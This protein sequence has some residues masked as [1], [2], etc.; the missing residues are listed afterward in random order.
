VTPPRADEHYTQTLLTHLHFVPKLL[1][2]CLTTS[3]AWS[4]STPPVAPVRPVVDDY[5]GTRVTDPYRWME[6]RHSA[7]FL[8]WAKKEN[9]YTRTVLAS[10]PNRDKLLKRIEELDSGG[11]LVYSVQAASGIVVYLKRGPA[12]N[13]FKL[14]LR[15]GLNGTETLLLDPNAGA[16][17]GKHSS[18]DYL[19]LSPNGAYVVVGVSEGGSEESVMCFIETSTGRT[20]PDRIDRTEYAHP[21]WLPDGK[22]LFYN[23]FAKI[24]PGAPETAKYLNSKAY[25]HRLGGDPEHDPVILAVDSAPEVKITPVDAPHVK[26][27]K[28]SS[29]A[30]GLISHGAAFELT[31]YVKA[32][33][34]VASRKATWRKLA[35][36]E[37]EVTNATLHNDDIYLLSHKDASRYKILQVSARDPDLNKALSVIPPSDVVIEEMEVAKDALYIK[38]LDAG[39]HKLRRMDYTTHEVTNVSGTLPG[40]ISEVATAP[41]TNGVLFPVVTWA[42][43]ARWYAYDP[44]MSAPRETTLLPKNNTDTSQFTFEEVRATAKDGTQIPLSLIHKRGL[45]QDGARPTWLTGYGAYGISMTPSFTP[46]W[47]ALLERGGLV[48]VAHVR[49]GGE[50][51]EDWHNAGRQATKPNTYLDLIACAEFLI[52]R[53]YTQPAK[54]AIQGGSAGGITVGMALAERPDLFRVVLS[55][56]GDSN[57]L[58]AEYETDGDANALEYGSA[59]NEAGFKALYAVDAFLHIKDGTGYPATLLT[60]GINDPRVAPWQPG[61]MAARLQAANSSGRPIVLRVDYDAGHG[62]GSTR[63]Q[64]DELLAD[65]LAFMLWQTGE[66]DFQPEG[67]T[68]AH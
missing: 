27:S 61:K 19:Q 62:I 3:F 22:A 28:N 63:S 2:L 16:A 57:A 6:D 60:T 15:K 35:D 31:V 38:V 53:H 42:Q 37:D 24:L 36:L 26:T 44:S 52:Q 41:D 7:E 48:A 12:D 67:P 45:P 13:V 14:Y 18:I 11:T 33:K 21:A 51:G 43:P 55:D 9:D 65:Q 1:A 8:D 4:A 56:A 30:V 66:P 34:A 58:R 20:L 50:L 64:R 39:V 5:F 68:A 54:L 25:L 49:G 17:Q 10:I 32:L 47:F 46:G 40:G 29:Y 23:R 59:K